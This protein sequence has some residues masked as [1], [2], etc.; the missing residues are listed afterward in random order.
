M[1]GKNYGFIREHGNDDDVFVHASTIMNGVPLGGDEVCQTTPLPPSFGDV[2]EGGRYS[3]AMC[4]VSPVFHLGF[5]CFPLKI[6]V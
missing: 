6:F 1:S 3:I 5:E 4:S 2:I